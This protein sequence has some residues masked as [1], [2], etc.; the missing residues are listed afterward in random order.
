MGKEK[1]N[2]KRQF[3]WDV[4][5][6][7]WPTE[8]IDAWKAVVFPNLSEGSGE[9]TAKNLITL[10]CD[11]YCLWSKGAFALQPISDPKDKKTLTIRFFWQTN[12]QPLKATNISLLVN[13]DS[14]KGLREYKTARLCDARGSAPV[15]I[16]TGDCF[17]ITTDDPDKRPLPSYALLEMQW[18]LQRVTGMAGA[19]DV[20]DDIH[21]GFNGFFDDKMAWGG[22]EDVSDESSD[23][24]NLGLDEARDESMLV[25]D[26]SFLTSYSLPD[27]VPGKSSLMP[28][29]EGRM[30]TEETEGMEERKTEGMEERKTEGMEERKTEGMEERST[31]GAVM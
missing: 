19:A 15:Y 8:K 22:E 5:K 14:T 27:D 30:H 11:A 9:E 28:S 3:F 23:I 17:T 26:E 6:C 13:P 25:V 1:P 18:F 20:E 4:L 24:S 10:S 16:K 29:I 21:G 31:E 12:Q 2:S 7:F